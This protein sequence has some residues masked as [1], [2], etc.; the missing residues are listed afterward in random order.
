MWRRLRPANLYPCAGVEVGPFFLRRELGRGSFSRVFLAEQMNLENRLVVVKVATHLT[1]EPWLLARVRHPHVA[2]VVS[3]ALVEDC[4]FHLICMPFWG[5]ATL[6]AVLAERQRHGAPLSGT[7]LLGDLDAVAAPEFPPSGAVRPAREI[8]AALSYDQ[9]VAWIGARL[10]DALD[11]AFSKGIAHGDVKPS[12]I[13]LTAD[14]SPM[15][16]DF[17]L[18]RDGSP[19]GSSD[20]TIDPGGTVAYM[21]PERLRALVDGESRPGSSNSVP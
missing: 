20:D 15:L 12:N 3:H 6:S 14:G 21:S 1:R 2:D 19:P 9:A 16:L 18:A 11:Y 13:L 4:G 10:S 5:G 17:N 8:L 7:D